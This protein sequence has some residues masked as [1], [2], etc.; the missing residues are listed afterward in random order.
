M[1]PRLLFFLLLAV[2]LRAQAVPQLRPLRCGDG[3]APRID[4]S[5]MDGIWEKAPAIGQLTQ[6]LPIEGNPPTQRS[7]IRLCYDA[8][9][10]YIGIYCYDEPRLVRAN[11]MA[12]DANLDPDDRVEVWVDSFGD[13]SFAYWFQIG[14]GGSKGDALLSDGGQR[15]NKR[16]DGVFWAKSRMVA[17]GW[18][19]EMALPFK[20]LAFDPDASHWGF[21]TR[22]LRK[23]SREEM[24]WASPGNAYSFFDLQRG[25]RLL[26]LE[27][28]EQGLGIDATPYLKAAARRE[29]LERGDFQHT[30]DFGGELRYRLTPSLGLLLT[31]RTD[32]AE[33]EVDS[34]QVNLSRFPLFFPEK[35][36]FFLEDADL[37]EFGS[38]D[39]SGTMLPFFSR[40]VGRDSSGEPVTILGGAKL[41]GRIDGWSVGALTTV[42][43]E[44][45]GLEEKSLSTARISKQVSKKLRV[46]GIATYGR[47]DAEGDAASF[48]ADFK[49]EDDDLFGDGSTFDLWGYYVQ[50]TRE[51]PGGDGG[52]YGAQA[53]YKTRSVNWTN[54][55]HTVQGGFSPELGF[56]RRTDIRQYRSSFN[57][58]LWLDGETF[59]YLRF[60]V[61]PTYTTDVAG[62]VDSWAV[63]VRWFG[64]RSQQGDSL[65]LESHRIFERLPEDFEIRSGITVPAAD[66]TMTRHFASF[67]FSDARPLSGGV[68]LEYGDFYDGD[69]W[70]MTLTPQLIT[71]PFW[72]LSGSFRDIRVKLRAG[73]F[74]TQ[75]YGARLDV[76]LSPELSW[77]NFVQY[78]STSRSVGWQSRLRW[79][80][81]PGSDL[82]VLANL[83]WERDDAGG[84]RPDAP[85]VSNAQELTIKFVYLLRF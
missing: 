43:E 14:P 50:S 25:G 41:A 52:A 32:F 31:Y 48:G 28:M 54:S 63:P 40:R 67:R 51:G 77:R 59:R 20:T 2:T 23:E 9:F 49:F 47:P 21:N 57:Y 39:R 81:D 35:R 18:T 68:A 44:H 38:P 66:Y 84:L 60:R 80:L 72:Q 62:D 6:V 33:T 56:V 1:L 37:F 70:Q 11:L 82:F 76:T 3:E 58:T 22:R 71:S 15:F 61:A 27:G 74:D 75:V 10:L 12:R 5:L 64:I 69:I 4:G 53:I 46:G 65:D 13:A 8:D 36:D 7:V 45:S 29:R 55:F 78:D 26:G 24:R 19:A 73:D 79:T 83:G 30:G 17:D 16:W 42:L 34:R 85:L